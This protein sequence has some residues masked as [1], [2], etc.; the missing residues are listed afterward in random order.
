VR[1]RCLSVHAPYRCA[2]AGSCCRAGWAIPVEEALIAPLRTIGIHI[3]PDRLAPAEPDGQCLFFEAGAGRLCTIH[4]LG[5]PSLLPSA[6]RHFPRVV[7]RDPRGASVTL[8]HFCPTAAGL[9]FGRVP[10]AIVDAP[11]SLAV[12]GALEGLDAT[13]VLPPLLARGVLIDWDGYSAWEEAAVALFDGHPDPERAVDA[14]VRATDACRAWRPGGETLAS[15]VRR[16]FADAR[17]GD[18]GGTNCWN[19]QGRAVSAF[20]AAHAFASWAAYEPDGLRSVAGAVEAAL[21]TLRGQIEDPDSVTREALIAAMSATDLRL[22]HAGP[23]GVRSLF[24]DA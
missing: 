5:G 17:S 4:R 14:L 13:E 2:H 18:R 12:D 16:A 9:L 8:S 24:S 23:V 7:V 19:G 10:L 3:G 21:G 22:R 1:V 6:C 20:L 11:P 15:A